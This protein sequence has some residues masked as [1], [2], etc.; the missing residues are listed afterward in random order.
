MTNFQKYEK[1]RFVVLEGQP[2]NTVV[3]PGEK[4]PMGIIRIYMNKVERKPGDPPP[5]SEDS[6]VEELSEGHA[7]T[8]NTS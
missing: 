8:K 2:L 5:G 1:F 7:M 6:E 3:S 4:I